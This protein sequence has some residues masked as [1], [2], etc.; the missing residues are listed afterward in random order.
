MD[1]CRRILPPC[2]SKNVAISCSKWSAVR[3]FASLP[4][5]AD[6]LQGLRVDDPPRSGLSGGS[7]HGQADPRRRVLHRPS[8]KLP[9]FDERQP[10]QWDKKKAI[11]AEA[12]QADRRWRHG[13]A[14]RRQHDLRSG[15]AAGRP[16][17]AHRHQLACRWPTCSPRTPI[18]TWCWSADTSIRGPA[19]RSGPMPTRCSS[20]STCAARSS[21]WRASTTRLF[22][23][24]PAAGRDRA[25]HDARRRRSDR[26]G[27]QH[28]VRPPEPGPSV[29]RWTTSSTW[30][31]TTKFRPTG[32]DR[33]P[34]PPACNLHVADQAAD[35]S[36]L[37]RTISFH[38]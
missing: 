22:Q 33:R 13:A 24:Q 20:G 15:P 6:Q 29:C 31:S 25:G 9:H 11:A 28:E 27:R 3:G 2:W 14:G 16:A 30:S 17:A 8:P 23:Q 35:E 18:T 7:G 34:P 36:D 19:W 12:R 5:L 21:A 26:R 4:E 37:P 38:Q 10:A 1:L 32:S